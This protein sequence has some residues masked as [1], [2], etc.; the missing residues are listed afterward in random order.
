MSRRAFTLIELLVVISIIAVLMSL[1]LPA[2]KKSKELALRSLCAANLHNIHLGTMMF[3]QEH[4][5]ALAPLRATGC[6]PGGCDPGYW[7]W[8]GGTPYLCR[9]DYEMPP[10]MDYFNHS[11]EIFYCPSNPVGPD[12][13]FFSPELQGT[14]YSPAWGW[15]QM[16]GASGRQAYWL[17]I[18]YNRLFEVA[19]LNGAEMAEVITDAPD[20]GLWSDRNLWAEPTGWIAANHPWISIVPSLNIDVNGGAEVSGRNLATLNGDVRWAGIGSEERYRLL[21][22][23]TGVFA[24]Y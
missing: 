14:D 12:T 19:N 10:F 18:T 21:I 5:G 8:D 6:H 22:H 4:D 7:R 24:S 23:S 16:D 3:A 15:R 9:S 11:R 1:L 2:I 17:N 20:L 13:G